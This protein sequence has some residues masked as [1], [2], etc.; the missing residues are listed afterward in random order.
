[1]Y[2]QVR[3]TTIELILATDLGAH[4]DLIGQVREYSECSASALS[5]SV[6]A[7][8]QSDRVDRH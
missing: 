4:F 1:M 2:Q 7:F 3:K 8:G 5:A 6:D